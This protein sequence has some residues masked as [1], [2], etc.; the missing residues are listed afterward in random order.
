VYS[1]VLL[2]APL[3]LPS[4]TFTSETLV[5]PPT[6]VKPTSLQDP[7]YERLGSPQS[8]PGGEM[9][10]FVEYRG[11][12]LQRRETFEHEDLGEVGRRPVLQERGVARFRKGPPGIRVVDVVYD[13]DLD[14]DAKMSF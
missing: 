14:A 1:G 2:P 12:H 8:V 7:A 11:A 5:C 10:Q 6:G 4:S 9:G 3:G 13:D